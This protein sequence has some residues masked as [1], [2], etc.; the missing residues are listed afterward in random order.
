MFANLNQGSLVHVLSLKDG[1]KYSTCTIETVTNPNIN[2]GLYQPFNPQNRDLPI[3]FTVNMNGKSVLLG[4][5]PANSSFTRSDDYIVTDS[6]DVMI[7][8][9]EG[10]LQTNQNVIDNIDVYKQNVSAC[11]DVLKQLSPQFAKETDRDNAIADLYSKVGGLDN[12]LDTILT[13]LSANIKK[14]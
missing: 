2:N 6:K 8:Q 3:A 9:V 1:L 10:I 5:I 4:G 7:S 14:E 12:K 13:T 11:N